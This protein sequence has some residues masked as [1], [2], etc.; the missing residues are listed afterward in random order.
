[1][2]FDSHCHL[3]FKAFNDNR[4]EVLEKCRKKDTKMIVVGTQQ[5]T[6]KNGVK[7]AGKYE[8]IKT[9]VGLHP[10]QSKQVKVEEENT[11]FVARGEDFDRE[12]YENLITESDEVVGVGETGLDKHHIPED[13]DVGKLMDEQWA[14]FLEHIKL[15]REY[16]LPIVMHIRKAHEEMLN[17]LEDIEVDFDGVV[18][19]F[20]SK[21]KYAKQY[22]D[23]GFNIG[24]TGII[25]F[26]PKSSNP[27]AQH[28][29]WEAVEQV[30]LDKLLVET[31]APFLAPQKYRGN[32]AEPWMT[33]EV[34]KKVA[35]I[36]DLDKN[37]VENKTA[38]N[39]KELFD[40]E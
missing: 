32:T 25:T 2:I 10:I 6:S 14:A 27:Q 21:W 31:D 20:T 16:D 36:K 33:E 11:S 8:G 7:L 9:T 17:R 37:K 22:L 29:L 15:A 30:P 3:Q 34:I 40:I 19:C 4:A 1:M 13:Q 12:F 23:Y 28:D 39:C 35:D 26:P 18:H 5:D 38:E 24:F